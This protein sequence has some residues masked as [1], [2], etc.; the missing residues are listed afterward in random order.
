MKILNKNG[1]EKISFTILSAYTHQKRVHLRFKHLWNISVQK[2][3]S[4]FFC[5]Q[6]LYG[7]KLRYF[8]NYSVAL[9]RMRFLT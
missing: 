3:A 7:R 6:S 2:I 1:L 4:N 8:G 9:L 5:A